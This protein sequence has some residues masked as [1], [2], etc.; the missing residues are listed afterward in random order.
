MYPEK[1]SILIVGD[2]RPQIGG[3]ARY[4]E[5]LLNFLS[6]RGHNVCLFHS[7]YFGKDAPKKNIFRMPFS[8]L[9]L[10]TLALKGFFGVLFKSVRMNPLLLLRP[11]S[12][13]H[14]VVLYA[15]CKEIVSQRKIDIIHSMHIDLRSLACIF[16]LGKE[17]PVVV[18]A[19]GYD[20]LTPNS[21]FVYYLRRLVCQNAHNITV[22]TEIKRKHL[23]TLYE[24]TFVVVPNFISSDRTFFGRTEIRDEKRLC[25]RKLEAKRQLGFKDHDI[26]VLF[27]TRLVKEKGIYELIHAFE[28]LMSTNDFSA[29]VH[30]LI[31][32]DGP[33]KGNVTRIVQ[34]NSA[35]ASNI[36]LA[37]NLNQKALKMFY[38]ASDILAFPTRWPETIPM[39]IVEA[40]AHGDAVVTTNFEGVE[41]IIMHK[42]NGLIISSRNLNSLFV[43]LRKLIEGPD[44]RTQI[45]WNAY[46]TFLEKFESEL[47]AAKIEEIY[48]KVSADASN[49]I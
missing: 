42:Y 35:L 17:I 41:E 19:H 43:Y 9:H 18:S 20:T 29:R 46:R 2:F 36:H 37:F 24:R 25:E 34:S 39:T 45:G 13:L 11:K 28:K 26:L 4:V 30:L 23:E 3:V 47:V 14:L 48:E 15:R 12:F 6:E 1:L 33:E 49:A 8:P 5:E 31:T 38:A 10:A 40:M 21:T 27:A 22:Q 7:S 44:L 16:A 32:G